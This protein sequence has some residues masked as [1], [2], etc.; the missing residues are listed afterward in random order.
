MEVY[1]FKNF[2]KVLQISELVVEIQTI[3]SESDLLSNGCPWG[4]SF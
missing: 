3:P 4:K 1:T 2:M